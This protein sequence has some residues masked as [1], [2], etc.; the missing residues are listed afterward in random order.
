MIVCDALD[1]ESDWEPMPKGECNCGAVAFEIRA[2]LSDVFVC[3]CSICRRFTGSN[4]IAVVIVDNAAF[5][6]IRGTEQIGTWKKPKADCNRG[7]A[8]SADQHCQA[9]T[10]NLACSCLPGCSLMG[11]QGSESHIMSGLTRR[12]IGMK[13]VTRA[14]N[15][16]KLSRRSYERPDLAVFARIGRASSTRN[17]RREPTQIESF[18]A[19][20]RYD[21]GTQRD[22]S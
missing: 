12:R 9:Q 11:L 22:D 19:P 8:V 13:S 21:L 20:Q 18:G 3:H 1:P 4:G 17:Q 16:Q 2:E 14:V 15:T 10:M 6:W 7:F 5:R